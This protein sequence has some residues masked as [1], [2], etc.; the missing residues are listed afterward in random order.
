MLHSDFLFNYTFDQLKPMK[1]KDRA[2]FDSLVAECRSQMS[3]DQS[4]NNMV[5]STTNYSTACLEILDILKKNKIAIPKDVEDF[6]MKIS[7]SK[8]FRINVCKK[9]LPRDFKKINELCQIL[10]ENEGS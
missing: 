1:D 10:L 8:K 5:D 4:E 2:E 6:I 3:P 7:T 9:V